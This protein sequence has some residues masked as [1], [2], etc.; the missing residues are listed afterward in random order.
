MHSICPKISV[1][2][3]SYNQGQFLEDT[4][5]S[6]LGQNY[7]N[8]E[9]I[10]IDGGSKDNSVEIIKKYE[11]KIAY[12]VSEKDNGQAHAINKGFEK[13]TGDI[14]CWLN[15]DDVWMPNI[16]SSVVAHLDI[17]K[18][19]I[20]SGNC[21]HFEQTSIGIETQGYDVIK[22]AEELELLEGDYLIQPSTFWTSRAWNTVGELKVSMNFVFDWD[23]FIRAQQMNVEFKLDSKPYSIYR[24]HSSHKTGTGGEK[25]RQEII[26]I[27]KIYNQDANLFLIEE[28]TKDKKMLLG[29][30]FKFLRFFM[31]FFRIQ[32]SDMDFIRSMNAKKYKR[33]SKR[34]F[35]AMY[36]QANVDL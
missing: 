29:L 13:A 5:L 31:S 26:N 7:S 32:L 15:S 22:F 25:R 8:L 9:Y 18:A 19:Q 2:T 20:L 34:K 28:L 10:I 6:V 16:L 1:V 35:K 17:S 12:W 33:F 4:I 27:Y 14:L 11:K 36:Y 24:V 23:W 30:P 21:I 3:P